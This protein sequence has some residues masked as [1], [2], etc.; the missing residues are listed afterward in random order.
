MK[1][2]N[3][4]SSLVASAALFSLAG[5]SVAQAAHHETM[6]P[7]KAI[8]VLVPGNDSGVSGTVVFTVVEGGVRV[9]A[10]VKG[11]TPGKHG[12][13]VHQYGDLSKADLTS[14]GGHF[15]P[16]GH[17]HAA[18]TDKIRHVGDLGNIEAN[19]EGVATYDRVDAELS[20]A[21]EQSIL[22]RAVIIHAGTDD[23]KSQPTG[24]AGGRVAGGVIAIAK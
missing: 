3:I 24:D 17:V 11:L 18:P 23:L 13:H 1:I 16:A 10:D 21:G 6:G 9:Q 12:F 4:V 14:T 8:A 15:N 19:A 7:E 2:R 20:L 22:G 5:L